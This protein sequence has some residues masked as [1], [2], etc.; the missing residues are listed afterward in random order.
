[1]HFIKTVLAFCIFSCSIFLT[2]A[3]VSN[4]DSMYFNTVF[5]NNGY[6][7]DVNNPGN[8]YIH[9]EIT[10]K[11]N[12]FERLNAQFL[13]SNNDYYGSYASMQVDTL[14]PE[15][16]VNS[17]MN[18]YFTTNANYAYKQLNPIF[19]LPFTLHHKTSKAYCTFTPSTNTTTSD[20]N[21]CF[22]MITGSGTH[23]G[24]ELIRGEGYQNNMGFIKDSLKQIGD[25]YIAFRPLLDFRAFYRRLIPGGIPKVLNSEFPFPSQITNYLNNRGTPYGTN[26]LIESIALVKYL[27]SKYKKVIIAGLSFGG[28]YTLLN[29]F[30]SEPEGCLIS[31]GYTI[32]V[33]ETSSTND[34]QTSHFGDLFYTLNRDSVKSKLLQTQ[35][36]FLFSWSTTGD[37]MQESQLHYTENY[38][39]G[40]TNTQYFYNYPTHTFPPFIAFKNLQDSVGLK[41]KAS[42]KVV[43]T[44]C[45]PVEAICQVKICGLK[46]FSFDVFKDATFFAH[47]TSASD[48]MLLSFYQE[49]DFQIRNVTDSLGRVG[50][51]SDVFTFKPNDH[52]QLHEVKRRFNCTTNRYDLAFVLTESPPFTLI[53]SKNG[54]LDTLQSLISDSLFVEWEPGNYVIQALKDAGTCTKI[55]NDPII[56]RDSLWWSDVVESTVYDC[57]SSK[58]KCILTPLFEPVHQLIG[59]RDGLSFSVHIS[60]KCCWLQNGN[61]IFSSLID[62]NGCSKPVQLTISIQEDSLTANVMNSEYDCDSNK[63]R[64]RFALKGKAPWEMYGY[65]NGTP[66]IFTSVQDTLSV[67]LDNGAHWF[68]T[69]QDQYGCVKNINY[70]ES[71]ANESIGINLSTPIFHCDSNKTKIDFAFS[72]KSPW[73]VNYTKNGIAQQTISVQLQNSLFLR[74]EIINFNL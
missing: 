39:N 67:Y 36:E 22:L 43:S 34:Y 54:I 7:N 18:T 33:D 17:S 28:Q 48:S 49:G 51:E 73:I 14:Y 4:A 1:M 35:T 47:Y 30:E 61:Y 13:F 25:V 68:Q 10:S 29:A 2:K 15:Q 20:C 74:M 72:G 23:N 60:Q 45:N 12:L 5:I 38:M 19:S 58:V 6:I 31:G 37:V 46:P 71:V 52:I 32:L 3:Q 26:S 53:Y 62:S 42:L 70:F 63:Q 16:L 40:T 11:Q 64:I 41:A 50:F 69:I 27:K 8:W 21:T 57:D 56:L 55:L 9:P 24:T 59:T 65:S 66:T 44:N